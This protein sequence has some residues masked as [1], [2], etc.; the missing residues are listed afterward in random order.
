[1]QGDA[2]IGE[3]K[4]MIIKSVFVALLLVSQRDYSVRERVSSVHVVCLVVALSPILILL[5]TPQF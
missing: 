5:Y 3:T 1:M 4:Y 2:G